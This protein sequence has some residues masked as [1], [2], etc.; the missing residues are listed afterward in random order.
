MG[1][2]EVGFG[3]DGGLFAGGIL[4]GRETDGKSEDDAKGRRD[5]ATVNGCSVFLG[6]EQG[7]PGGSLVKEGA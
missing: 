4:V 5:S 7:V 2:R 1:C 3:A 6:G